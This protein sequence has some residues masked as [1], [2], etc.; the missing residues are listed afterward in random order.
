MPNIMHAK[1]SRTTFQSW[2]IFFQFK[3]FLGFSRHVDTLFNFRHFFMKILSNLQR[4]GVSFGAM[5]LILFYN[6]RL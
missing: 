5:F 1:Y 2:N 3:D 6:T 4:C